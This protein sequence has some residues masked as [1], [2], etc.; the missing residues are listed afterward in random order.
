MSIG[1]SLRFKVLKK[2]SILQQLPIFSKNLKWICCWAIGPTKPVCRSYCHTIFLRHASFIPPGAANLL[3]VL[4]QAS[5]VICSSPWCDEEVHARVICRTCHGLANLGK[6]LPRNHQ[7]PQV[8]FVSP[9]PKKLFWWFTIC[10]IHRCWFFGDSPFAASASRGCR[11]PQPTRN[12]VSRFYRRR[13][14]ENTVAIRKLVGDWE[15]S[16]RWRFR[17]RWGDFCLREIWEHN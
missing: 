5:G 13:E 8:N 9:S 15:L 4:T 7:P 2:V 17:R 14:T 6:P 1:S 10:R 11:P 12:Q 16:S 3:H